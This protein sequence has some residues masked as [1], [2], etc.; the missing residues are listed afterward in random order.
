MND[1]FILIF[2]PWCGWC[3]GAHPGLQRLRTALPHAEFELLPSGLFC[4]PERPDALRR[5]YFWQADQQIA[6][7]T[8][9][10]FSMHYR[11][12]ILGDAE[13]IFDAS[14][15][16]HAWF[17]LSQA[18]PQHSLDV[19]HAVQRLRYVEGDVSID[20]HAALGE[21]YGLDSASLARQLAG[22]WPDA[23]HQLVARARQLMQQQNIQ[24]VPTLLARHGN[25]L[26]AV[27]NQ[28]LF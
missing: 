26:H 20:A 10:P 28:Q 21:R 9:Q 4:R 19:L 22:P 24:G 14:L 5:E 27:S 3:Y 13:Q 18:A 8:G 6:T 2:D 15:A 12:R 7:R 11:E 16:T 25:S 23:L 17:L 1:R